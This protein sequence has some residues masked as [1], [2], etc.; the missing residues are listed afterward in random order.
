MCS[1]AP[2]GIP[3]IAIGLPGNI[4]AEPPAIDEAND[5]TTITATSAPPIPRIAEFGSRPR[6]GEA[7][8]RKNRAARAAKP[9]LTAPK[10]RLRRMLTFIGTLRS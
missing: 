9:W 3:G 6:W 8:T 2:G 10:N 1:I 5:A 4:A 7:P